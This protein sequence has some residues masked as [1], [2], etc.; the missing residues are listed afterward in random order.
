MSRVFFGWWVA[1]ALAVMVFLSTGI[2]FTVGPF[3][4]D[5]VADLDIDRASFS[6]VVSLSL[7]LYGVFMPFVGRLVDRVGARPI[8][9]TGTLVLAGAVAATGQV[10]SLWQ[11]YLVYGV[12][13]ALGLAATGHVVGAAVIVRWFTRRRATALSLLGGASMAGMSLLVPVAT[14]LILT[15]GWRATY[16]VMGAAILVVLLPL[17][18]WLVRDSPEV[19]GLAPDGVTGDA[20]PIGPATGERTE[21][22][23]ALRTLSFWQL[24]GGMFTCGFSMSLLSAHGLPMLT[25]HG[26]HAML[27]SGAIGV[28]GGTSVG[29]ALVLGALADQVG[30]R[31]VLAWL[32]GTRAILLVAMFLIRDHP[33]A[34]VALAAL[35]GASM[36]GSLA[37]TSA[38]T[39]DIFGRFSVGSVFGTIFL[40]HQ[41]GAAAGVWLGG[42]LFELSG[43][44]GVVFTVASAQLL[45]AAVLSLTIDERVRCGPR[46]GLAAAGRPEVTR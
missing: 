32:Y 18:G 2:R 43:G 22:G 13:V 8:M 30:R 10:T 26:Y 39:A 15:L 46:F 27:A 9:V 1:L 19:M 31:S 21:V 12:C 25:D 11:L 41:T 23:T 20:P 16:G 36:S 35:G 44:Y 33:V 14:W 29:F 5:V 38:L 40:V 17:T 7:F 28:L 37:M 45:A 24:S 4:K 3:L 6:L 42:V 34:L